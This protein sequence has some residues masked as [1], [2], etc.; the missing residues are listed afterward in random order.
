MEDVK[1]FYPT[2][3]SSVRA[4]VAELNGEVVGIIGVALLRP[5]GCAFSQFKP[6]LKPFLS[7][8]AV[9]RLIK[10]MQEAMERS[11]VPVRAIVEEG[12]TDHRVLQ[13]IGFRYVG[14]IDGDGVYE[15]R[16]RS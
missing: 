13:R 16:G 10:H 11:V 6:A 12:V 4:W 14:R 5:V 15:Y 1:L 7:H 9:W 8:P 2:M 3:T